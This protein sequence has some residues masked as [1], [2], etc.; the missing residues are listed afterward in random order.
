MTLT[1]RGFVSIIDYSVI[2]IE[3]RRQVKVLYAQH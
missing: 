3:E 2:A 1:K